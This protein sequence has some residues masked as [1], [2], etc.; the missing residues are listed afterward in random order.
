MMKEGVFD[1]PSFFQIDRY[2]IAYNRQV[3]TLI[4]SRHNASS[5]NFQE[6]KKYFENLKNHSKK[7]GIKIDNQ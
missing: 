2:H 6:S 5:K 4:V 7:S 3:N 1:T